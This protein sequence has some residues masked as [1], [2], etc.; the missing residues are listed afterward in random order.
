MGLALGIDIGTSGV[1]AVAID[2]AG[3]I[4]ADT[5][6]PMTLPVL[7]VGQI[8]QDPHVWWQ[9]LET[10]LDLLLAK[11]APNEVE[12]IA[13]DGTSGTILP[14]D[15]AGK[16]LGLALMYNDPSAAELAKGLAAHAPPHTAALGAT[17]PLARALT[18]KD[19]K[20]L[21]RILHQADWIAGKFCGRFDTSDENNALKTGYDPLARDWPDW[22]GKAGLD[23]ALL[24]NVVPAGT[25]I[26][27]VSAETAER[28]RLPQSAAVVAGTTDGCAAFLA[29]GANEGG[30][31]VTSLGTTLTIKLLSDKPVF[32]PQY[33][34]Y[35]HRIGERWLA[36]GASNTGGAAL[37]KFFTRTRM[38]EL[39]PR[40][41]PAKPTGLDYYPLPH[42][43]ERFPINDPNHA[44]KVDPRPAD[45]AIFFQGLLEGIAKIE[46]LGYRHLGELGASPLKRLRTV[47]GGAGNAAW[48]EIRKRALGVPFAGAMSQETAAGTARL[49]WRGIGVM[50]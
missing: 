50:F 46:A 29:T 4:V 35:S 16:P 26:G 8:A 24:P 34:I 6:Q 37:Q 33:G 3:K 12:A 11:I 9:A 42:A 2:R 1:R 17:S 36:G 23:L 41:D 28:F 39:E 44:P 7:E 13:V 31:G 49:A 22:I 10:A 15:E 25:K 45:D 32:A 19:I 40:L 5:S 27:D 21:K 14:V 38:A 30:D 48:S 18:F 20:G 47:G 43:G